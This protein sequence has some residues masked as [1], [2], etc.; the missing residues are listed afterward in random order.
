MLHQIENLEDY[1]FP[2]SQQVARDCMK[3]QEF[4][5]N[6]A[7]ESLATEDEGRRQVDFSTRV[8]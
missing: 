4:G 5:D 6:L 8:L 2:Q 1:E 7:T 3:S